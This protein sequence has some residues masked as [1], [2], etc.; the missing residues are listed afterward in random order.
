[1]VLH[2]RG[3][4]RTLKCLCKCSVYSKES[5]RSYQE[6]LNISLCLSTEG[7]LSRSC[8]SAGFEEEEN[9]GKQLLLSWREKNFL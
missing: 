1:M 6:K 9:F 4:H 2:M 5:P 8:Q 7:T 3:W